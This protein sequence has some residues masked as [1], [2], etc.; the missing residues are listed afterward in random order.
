MVWEIT[1]T[2]L[3]ARYEKGERNFAGVDLNPSCEHDWVN[4]GQTDLREI[5]LH[6]HLNLVIQ[7]KPL[8]CKLLRS[9]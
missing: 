5:N 9:I 8:M 6:C 1:A 3:L 7:A 4:L 2:E